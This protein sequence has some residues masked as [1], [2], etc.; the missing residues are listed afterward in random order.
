MIIDELKRENR[1]LKFALVTRDQ[2]LEHIIFRSG[3]LFVPNNV[4]A[5]C[6]EQ[7]VIA[8]APQNLA[9]ACAMLHRCWQGWL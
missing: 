5:H 4:C 7:S 1:D 3:S 8:C 6:S 9:A 2:R